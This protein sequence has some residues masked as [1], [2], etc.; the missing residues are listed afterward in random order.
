MTARRK[1][2]IENDPHF[3]E[4]TSSTSTDASVEDITQIRR[5]MIAQERR[6]VK[7]TILTEFIGAFIVIPQHGLQKV[8]VYDISENGIAFDVDQNYGNLKDE[9]EVAM[10]V[11]MNQSTYFPFVVQIRNVRR[12]EDEGV[13]RVGAHFVK[14]TINDEALFHF[15][16]FIET[17][18]ASLRRDNGDVMVSNLTDL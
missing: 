2:Q 18:A 5:N 4:Q 9:E 1:A 11:Y 17:V 6:V 12:I 15:V 7:R 13:I 10:R 3:E 14:G 16:K 8:M